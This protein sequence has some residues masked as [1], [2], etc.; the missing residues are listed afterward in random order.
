MEEVLSQSHR[1]WESGCSHLSFCK[2]AVSYEISSS[3]ELRQVDI[4][5]FSKLCPYYVLCLLSCCWRW[6]DTCLA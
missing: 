4:F 2:Y 3:N 1:A 6:V 5:S